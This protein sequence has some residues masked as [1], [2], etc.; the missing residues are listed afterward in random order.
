MS[1]KEE[2]V[3]RIVVHKPHSI[4]GVI[5]PVGEKVMVTK[6][7]ARNFP[8]RLADV[9]VVEAQNAAQKALEESLA[10]AS[11]EETSVEAPK[12]TQAPQ[13][14]PQA[15]QAAKTTPAK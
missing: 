14:K 2:M 15:A 7:T 1:D 12:P 9:K 13:A 10:E 6:A 4:N 11:D 3:E 5:I 8:H